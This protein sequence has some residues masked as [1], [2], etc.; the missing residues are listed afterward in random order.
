MFVATL[1]CLEFGHGNMGLG[2]AIARRGWFN[3]GHAR[4]ELS[5]NNMG[6]GWVHLRQHMV[7]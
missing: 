5:C 3:W 6:W 4:L 2:L 1:G 7:G